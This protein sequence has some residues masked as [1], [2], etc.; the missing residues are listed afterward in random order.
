MRSFKTD[1]GYPPRIRVI[2]LGTIVALAMLLFAFPRFNAG[3]QAPSAATFEQ[4]VQEFDIPET[5]QFEAPPPPSRPSIPIESD[6]EDFAEDITIEETLL[7]E[8]EEW[9]VPAP[10]ADDPSSRIRFIPHDEPPVPIGGYAAIAEKLVYPAIAREAGIEGTVVLQA[11]VSDKGF[12]EDVVVLNGLPETGLDE[13]AVKAVRQ[14][15]FKPAK[16]RD[17][18]L[19]VWVAIP[20]HFVLTTDTDR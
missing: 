20:I 18:P 3:R 2:I 9:E 12:V 19:G 6:D 17:M 1:D 5:H 14:V 7:D 10:P 8:F 16:Q 15:R 11:F 4:I 13:A